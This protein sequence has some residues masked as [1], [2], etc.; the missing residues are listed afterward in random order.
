MVAY[1]GAVAVEDRG[2]A[3][4][5]TAVPMTPNAFSLFFIGEINTEMLN[6]N[7]GYRSS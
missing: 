1:L 3:L 7:T 2:E 6:T 4:Q 5:I